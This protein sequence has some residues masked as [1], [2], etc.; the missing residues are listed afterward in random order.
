MLLDMVLERGEGQKRNGQRWPGVH[1][2]ELFSII[3]HLKR[4]GEGRGLMQG[5]QREVIITI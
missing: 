4:R 3:F 1:G 2:M 5:M